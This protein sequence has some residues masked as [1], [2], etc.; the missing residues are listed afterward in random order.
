MPVV[1]ICRD[2]FLPKGFKLGGV[3]ILIR[4]LVTAD[5]PEF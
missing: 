5:W 2:G 3:L 1:M 4:R